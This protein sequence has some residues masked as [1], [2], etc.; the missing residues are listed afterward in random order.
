MSHPLF[1]DYP[2]VID[3]GDVEETFFQFEVQVVFGRQGQDV[4]DSC[5]MIIIVGMC[6][7]SYIVH[8]N[9]DGSTKEFVLSYDGAKDVIQHRLEGSWGVSGAKEHDS[10]FIE[11]VVCFEGSF[12]FVALLDA[13][14]VISPVD[15]QFSINVSAL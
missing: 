9:A 12:V 15:V 14:I 13:D 6:G 11:A 10:R 1:K 7:N 2:Q 5:S 8:V 3:T 4:G